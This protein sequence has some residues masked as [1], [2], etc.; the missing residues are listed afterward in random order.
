MKKVL[1]PT[2][3]LG[4]IVL[5]IGLHFVFPVCQWLAFPWSPEQRMMEKTFG[6]AFRDYAQRVRRWL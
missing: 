5:E 1:P 4:A 3:F 2:Y 6:D